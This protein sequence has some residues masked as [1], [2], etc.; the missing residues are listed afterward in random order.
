[1]KRFL[2]FVLLFPGIATAVLFALISIGVG[3]LP[4][5][6]EA[7]FVVGWG[8]IVGLIPALVCALVDL[9]L[10]KTRIPPVVG[11]TLVGY[12]IALLA[13][14]VIFDFGLFGR[15]LAFGLIGGIPAAVCSWLSG[16]DA[17]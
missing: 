1:M 17:S 10:G 8:Y 12:G 16:G 2:I 7:I 6:P 4:D 5:N 13:G 3:A 14:L 11:T 9:L 15:I